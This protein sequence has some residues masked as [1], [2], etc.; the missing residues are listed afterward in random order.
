MLVY[1]TLQLAINELP[2]NAEEFQSLVSNV[3][4]SFLTHG[5]QALQVLTEIYIQWQDI[6]RKLLLADDSVFGKN[7]D[8]I[9]DQLDLMSLADLSM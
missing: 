4:K 3:R 7:I 9:E 1:A 5:Q 6:R 2:V 8:D